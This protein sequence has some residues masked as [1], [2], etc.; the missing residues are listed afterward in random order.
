[1]VISSTVIAAVIFAFVIAFIFS[2]F[3]QGG[4]SVYSPLLLLLGFIAMYL[5]V[6]I[7]GVK[8]HHFAVRGLYFLPQEDD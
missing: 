2:M 1:M 8:S 3:G 6:H 7:P 5:H 4:G